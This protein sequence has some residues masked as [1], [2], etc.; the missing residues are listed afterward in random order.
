MPESV[1][2]KEKLNEIITLLPVRGE[3]ITIDGDVFELTEDYPDIEKYIEA[4]ETRT[5]RVLVSLGYSDDGFKDIPHLMRFNA[6]GLGYQACTVGYT[7][8]NNGEA[9]AYV[10]FVELNES[11]FHR[12]VWAKSIP[13]T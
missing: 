7:Y 3:N 9:A 10:L 13:L 6:G 5:V 8:K 4:I 11:L 2:F 1:L 12:K